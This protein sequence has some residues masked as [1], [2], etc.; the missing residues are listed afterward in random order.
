MAFMKDHKNR[1]FVFSFCLM[2]AM[3]SIV[4]CNK[5]NETAAITFEDA[6]KSKCKEYLKSILKDP[7]SYQ[8]SSW[9]IKEIDYNDYLKTKKKYP[10]Y[11]Y[12]FYKYAYT[13]IYRAKNSFGGYGVSE[14]I[15][16]VDSTGAFEFCDGSLPTY[17]RINE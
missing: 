14:A 15:F 16:L 5:G 3:I 10:D 4:A 8:S 9:V 13:N 12:K 11:D 6:T 7:D 1:L 17:M 2:L